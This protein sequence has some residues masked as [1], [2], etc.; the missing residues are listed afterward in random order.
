[1]SPVYHEM[2]GHL[3]TSVWLTK[4]ETKNKRAR[5]RVR[6]KVR[7]IQPVH[8]EVIGHLLTHVYSN[9]IQTNERERTSPSLSS[10]SPWRRPR[11][12]LYWPAVAD[13]GAPRRSFPYG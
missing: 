12:S 5:H 4:S 10:P 7:I 13:G 2:T 3:P 6:L 8:K 11:A 9:S 1:M